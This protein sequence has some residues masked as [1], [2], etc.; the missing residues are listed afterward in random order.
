LLVQRKG[1][2]RKHVQS[3]IPRRSF[4]KALG[5]DEGSVQTR[6]FQ[7]EK[8]FALLERYRKAEQ[9]NPGMD[10]LS[11]PGAVAVPSLAAE[12]GSKARMFEHTDV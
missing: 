6:S 8:P 1:T 3:S 2:E 4:T 9:G 7:I 10:G 5:R 11:H 12:S